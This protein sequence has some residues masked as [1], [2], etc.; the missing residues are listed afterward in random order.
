MPGRR[1]VWMGKAD[2]GITSACD[3]CVNSVSLPSSRLYIQPA[4]NGLREAQFAIGLHI[5][6]P[7]CAVCG[8]VSSK[9][10]FDKY[11]CR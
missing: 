1:L 9:L 6:A 3:G 8:H 2:L 11:V 7:T 10:A 5:C 4:G